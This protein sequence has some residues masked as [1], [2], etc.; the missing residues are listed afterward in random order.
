MDELFKCMQYAPDRLTLQHVQ[1]GLRRLKNLHVRCFGLLRGLVIL[2]ACLMSAQ[3]GQHAP[4]R[5]R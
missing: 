3:P 5:Q 4:A 1:Q 2:I